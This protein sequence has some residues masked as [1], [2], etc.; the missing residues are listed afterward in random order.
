MFEHKESIG[1]IGKWATKLAEQPINFISCS[2][3]KSQVLADFVADWTPTVTKGDPV[4]SGSVWEV[5]CDGEYC[6]LGSTVVAVLNSPSGIK[7]RYALQL[8][9]DNCTN[10][11][12]EYEGLLLVLRKARAVGARRLVILTDSKLVAGHIRKTYKAKKLLTVY[13][14]IKLQVDLQADKSPVVVKG[15]FFPRVVNQKYRIRGTNV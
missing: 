5:Q 15:P 1:R 10:N 12:A 7:L 13:N 14:R 4:V 2:A 11:M 3:M 8:N 6:H 9:C